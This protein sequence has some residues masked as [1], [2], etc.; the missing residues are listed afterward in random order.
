MAELE[1]ERSLRSADERRNKMENFMNS[2]RLNASKLQKEQQQQAVDKMQAKKVMLEKQR[3]LKAKYTVVEKKKG[4]PAKVEPAQVEWKKVD[5][6]LKG[7]SPPS[8]VPQQSMW[9][10]ESEESGVDSEYEMTEI[11]TPK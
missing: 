6:A 5:P 11:R 8:E 7:V 2:T 10:S 4:L 9:E 3:Q 1:Q